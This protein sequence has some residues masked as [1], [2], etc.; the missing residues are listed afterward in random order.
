M[1]KAKNEERICYILF[2]CCKVTAW[3][4]KATWK[5]LKSIFV[6]WC[7]SN[8]MQNGLLNCAIFYLYQRQGSNCQ[9]VEEVWNCRT[10]GLKCN[11]T[12]WRHILWNNDTITYYI[13]GYNNIIVL[14]HVGIISV[15]VVDFFFFFCIST[16]ISTGKMWGVAKSQS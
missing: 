8:Y 6:Y 4:S 3:L 9:G 12:T 2:E 14:E 10:S 15:C 16:I 5:I 1:C 11:P 7:F 13:V